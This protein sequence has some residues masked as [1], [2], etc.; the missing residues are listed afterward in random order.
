MRKIILPFMALLLLGLSAP[1][2]SFGDNH[3]EGKGGKFRE[4][5]KQ[6]DLSKE[7]IETLKEHRKANKT[8]EK[9]DWKKVKQLKEDIKAAFISGA[10]DEQVKDL[11]SKLQVELEK[12]K[13]ARFSKMIFM[14][15]LLNEEQ[16][17][18]FME[19]KKDRKHK[20]D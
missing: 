11:N 12:M 15:N 5:M 4:V 3:G 17:K 8:K 10:S 7:Q 20:E 13:E 18:K 1:V 2:Y 9:P 16:R 19:L 14:K 6:L